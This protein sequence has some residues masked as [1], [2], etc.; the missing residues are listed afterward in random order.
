MGRAGRDQLPAEC[1]T[2]Y[3]ENDFKQHQYH[4]NR[5]ND[6]DDPNKQKRNDLVKEL[7]LMQAFCDNIGDCQR[8][9]ILNYLGEPTENLMCNKTCGSC[10]NA[11][12]TKKVD[13]TECA[14]FILDFASMRDDRE[15]FGFMKDDLYYLFYAKEAKQKINHFFGCF[16]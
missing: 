8:M 3:G 12:K 4:I 9:I 6:E 10:I 16:T 14:E 5:I 15:N 2:F 13:M 11:I 1:I 7:H